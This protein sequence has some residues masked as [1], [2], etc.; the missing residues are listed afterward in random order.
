MWIELIKADRLHNDPANAKDTEPAAQSLYTERKS[1]ALSS[2]LLQRPSVETK[3]SC[4]ITS[5]HGELDS[6]QLSVLLFSQVY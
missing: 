4:Y 1:N 5:L 2:P 6:N 3:Q